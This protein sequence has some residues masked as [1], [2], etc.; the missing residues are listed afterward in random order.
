MD[1]KLNIILAVYTLFNY[2]THNTENIQI[3]WLG[4]CFMYVRVLLIPHSHL[5]LSHPPSLISALSS[6]HLNYFVT[7]VSLLPPHRLISRWWF[8]WRRNVS[9]L[10]SVIAIEY[11]WGGLSAEAETE[12]LLVLA[13]VHFTC[14][15]AEQT[16]PDLTHHLTMLLDSECGWNRSDAFGS[17]RD[18]C[19]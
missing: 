9:F 17:N 5:I 19:Q 12:Q 16:I 8:W 10:S 1:N 18:I 3:K 6:A 13:L 11:F 14:R 2:I 4:M 7:G 15:C